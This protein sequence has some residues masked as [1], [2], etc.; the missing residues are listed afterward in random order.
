MIT[1]NTPIQDFVIGNYP[2]KVKREDIC[3]PEGLGWPSFAKL[4][5]L[6]AHMS[7][8]KQTGIEVVGY[9]QN[10][11]SMAGWGVAA[12]ADALHMKA[13]IFYHD[14]VKGLPERLA[15]HREKWLALG[16]ED[17]PVEVTRDN[18]ISYRGRSILQ[19]RYKGKAAMLPLG[20]KFPET[21]VEVANEA[22]LSNLERFKTIVVCVGSGMMCS[23]ILRAL[24]K[25]VLL[26]GIMVKRVD[27]RTLSETKGEII[28][29]AGPG[30]I[31]SN[32]I[33]VNSYYDYEKEARCK[34]PFP[35][36]PIY[37]LKAW[38]WLTQNIEKL[39]HPVLFWNVGGDSK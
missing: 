39:E 3:I 33:L 7:K 9:P 5:G 35:C 6:H 24:P 20:L 19:E 25:G 17:V 27:G 23:G 10:K 28:R 36:H 31:L 15:F 2:V 13:V 21:V 11:I 34:C 37:D 29:H 22:R 8:L 30:C 1:K 38:E 32:F 4:R 12:V 18:I 16:A 26:I 14:Y